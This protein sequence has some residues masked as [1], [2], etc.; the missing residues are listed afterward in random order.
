[1]GWTRSAHYKTRISNEFW[2]DGPKRRE[3]SEHLRVD[4]RIILKLILGKCVVAW[5]GLIWLKTRTGGEA[6]EH[7]NKHSVS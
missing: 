2:L 4:G 6:Y 7:G 1:M 3:H 5:T